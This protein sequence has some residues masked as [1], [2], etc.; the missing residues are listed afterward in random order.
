MSGGDPA[1]TAQHGAFPVKGRVRAVLLLLF[2][3]GHAVFLIA[4]IVT[5]NPPP[6]ERGNPVLA[7]YRLFTGGQQQ[8]NMF[9]TIPLLHSL[10]ARIVVDDGPGEVVVVGSVLPGFTPYPRPEQSRYYVLFHRMMIQAERPSFF[11]A[12]LRRTDVLLRSQR[13]S[14]ITGHW[15]LVVDVEWTRTLIHSRRDGG[16]YVPASR[17]FDAANPGGTPR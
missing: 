16:L 15:A 7:F 12:Y 17:S 1:G 3:C 9:E 8:W 13:G 11:E 2:C 10:D 6:T 4:S 14:A 5:R